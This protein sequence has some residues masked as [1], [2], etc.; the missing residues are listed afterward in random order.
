MTIRSG[1]WKFID[2][3]GSGGFSDR[4]VRG[5]DPL[6]DGGGNRQAAPKPQG[7]AGQLYNMKN[8]PGETRNLYTDRPEIVDRLKKEM[9]QIVR[10]SKS[11]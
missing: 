8:D 6:A 4:G 9:A 10:N 1:D 3:R 5:G 2:G 7:P 11:R